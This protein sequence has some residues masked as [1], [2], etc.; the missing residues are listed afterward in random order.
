M[1]LR[2]SRSDTGGVLWV[3]NNAPPYRL[4]L[5]N[6]VR[7]LLGTVQVGLLER[8]D[9]TASIGKRPRDWASV[10]SLDSALA[11]VE[12]PSVRVSRGEDHRYLL[13]QRLLRGQRIPEAV[14]LG[15]WDQPAYWQVLLEARLRGVR[16]VGFYESTLNSQR[17][18]RGP[19]A[20]ARKWFFRMLD[21]VVTPGVGATEA[22]L[23]M[24]VSS[25]RVFQGFNAV[26]GAS[27][28]TSA[29]AARLALAVD[30]RRFD[31]VY[32]GQLI[33]RKNLESLLD[34]ISQVP[35]ATALIVGDGPLREGLLDRSY[36]LGLGE[37]VE[38]VGMVDNPE[39]PALLVRCRALVLP[40]TEEVWGLVV[41]EALACGLHVVV[42]SRAGVARDVAQM[43]GVALAE[44]DVGGLASALARAMSARLEPIGDPEILKHGP[45]QF[46][47]VFAAALGLPSDAGAS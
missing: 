32:V 22:I 43:E 47:Q 41:N 24:G 7:D 20:L 13:K 31:F 30:A 9:V 15:G 1:A 45:E 3:T 17:H 37:R 18:R 14:L 46:A 23:A 42:S 28:A 4:P 5:W 12:L 33:P 34:A 39:L 35:A 2:G 44:P 21:A 8:R 11:V 19:V 25:D 16:L 6:C 29:K 26:D 10:S 36:A 40:S 38:F 27:L